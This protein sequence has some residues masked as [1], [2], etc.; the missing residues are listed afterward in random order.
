[1][2]TLKKFFD[3]WLEQCDRSPQYVSLTMTS[4]NFFKQTLD[5]KWLGIKTVDFKQLKE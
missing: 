5:N 2:T 4:K 1:M 3:G